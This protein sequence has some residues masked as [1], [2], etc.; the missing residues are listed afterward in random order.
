MHHKRGRGPRA[1]S[2]VKIAKPWKRW[3]VPAENPE[4]DKHS[5]HQRRLAARDA[6]REE[7]FRA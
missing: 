2:R 7:G 4:H 3:G 5:D 1:R 6:V